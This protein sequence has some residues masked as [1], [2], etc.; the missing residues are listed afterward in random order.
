LK[1]QENAITFVNQNFEYLLRLF[2]EYW[3]ALVCFIS[4]KKIFKLV[5]RS[6]QILKSYV[7]QV[8][9]IC[10]WIKLYLF[11]LLLLTFTIIPRIYLTPL[12]DQWLLVNLTLILNKLQN[13]RHPFYNPVWSTLQKTLFYIIFCTKL[14]LLSCHFPSR[15]QNSWITSKKAIAIIHQS[16]KY[17]IIA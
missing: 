10:L 17:F 1:F 9:F 4:W 7:N 6:N 2:N 13:S 15:F 12:I 14:K 16:V 5:N 11:L 3:W 8:I